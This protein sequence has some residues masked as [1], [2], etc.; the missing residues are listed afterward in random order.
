MVRFS[1]YDEAHLFAS[2]KRADGY[3]A[4]VIHQ[5]A[6]H[7]WGAA[8]VGGFPVLVSA[9]SIPEDTPDPDRGSDRPSEMGLM[10]AMFGLLGFVLFIAASLFT[11]SLLVLGAALEFMAMPVLYKMMSVVLFVGLFYGSFWNVETDTSLSP[12]SA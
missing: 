3:F 7:I 8:V 5:N 11:G 10:V 9:D 6:G 12:T 4:E 2:M 1:T